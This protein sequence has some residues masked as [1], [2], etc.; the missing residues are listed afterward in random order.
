MNSIITL[1]LKAVTKIKPSRV[2]RRLKRRWKKS[3]LMQACNCVLTASFLRLILSSLSRMTVRFDTRKNKHGAGYAPIT[4]HGFFY[5]L[6]KDAGLIRVLFP[7]MAG[8]V[9]AVSVFAACQP[10]ANRHPSVD[11]FD[12][13]Y[14][15]LKTESP[16]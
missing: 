14:S 3:K 13:G 1:P 12:G 6:K 15:K 5:T 7:V 16:A 8:S 11:T 2:K 9:R 10:D 4:A